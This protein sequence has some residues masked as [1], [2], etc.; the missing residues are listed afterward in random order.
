VDFDDGV[1]QWNRGSEELYGYSREEAIGKQKERLLQT[2]VPGSTFDSLRASL[3]KHGTW[4]GELFHRAKDGRVLTVES[5]IELVL[6]G[7]RRL[8]LESTRDIT[9]QK[10]WEKRRQL[11]LAELSHR[12]SNT[13]TVVQSMARQTLRTTAGKND[14]VELFDGRLSA[15]ARSHNL[16]V[17]AHWESAEFGDLVRS[18]LAAYM[19][20]DPERLRLQG[21]PLALPPGLA[22]PF[23][24]VL[25]ELA[26]NAAKY[27]AFSVPSGKVLLSWSTE[28]LESGQRLKV[29]WQETD[30]PSVTL[31]TKIGFGGSLIE[32]SLAG[33]SVRRE[34][35]PEGLVC[36]KP[37]H[38][39]PLRGSRILVV[40]D[41]FLIVA[42]IEDTLG[43]AG[44]D[45]VSAATLA[46]GLKT[47]QEEQLSA[48]VLDFRLGPETT[49]ALADLLTTQSVPFVFYSGQVLP[50]RVLDRYSS[51]K[52]MTKPIAQGAL[53]KTMID[54]L[55][56]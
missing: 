20:D 10:K 51:A 42:S 7:Q 14:F 31:P 12:V 43:E 18:Q 22:T 8:V 34:F 17:E 52:V 5:Q 2:A 24:L 30:G 29:R 55:R 56:H 53:L 39:T 21:D 48:A 32:R 4:S 54:L 50:D 47:A 44:A 40:D 15:L 28:K 16:L 46:A 37:K 26:T 33:A 11:L 36:T 3:L 35:L 27:G 13:L 45:V 6:V 1:L 19:S 38:Q 23:G 41:E 25:H 49:E 9:D